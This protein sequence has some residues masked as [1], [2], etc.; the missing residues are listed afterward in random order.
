MEALVGEIAIETRVGAVTVSTAVLLVI[1]PDVAV[2]FEL[3]VLRLVATP[4]AL[5]EATELLLEF[6]VTEL[7]RSAVL[8]SV[9]VPVAVNGCVRPLAMEGLAGVTA[10]ETKVAAVTVSCAVPDLLVLGSVAVMVIG[11]PAA[12][13]VATP[14]FRPTVAV[15]VSDEVQFTDA[16]RFWVLL[17][18]YIPVAVNACVRPLA[19]EGLAGVTAME[20]KA[21]AVT[22]SCAVPDLLVLGSVAVMV[23][24]PPAA[25][26]VATPV[27]RPTVAVLVSDEV[28]F[29][30]A[31]RFWVL[32]SVYVP[33]AV[34]AWVKPLAIEGLAGV[35]A[36]ETKV[37]AVTVS[38]AVPDLL[39]LGSVAVMVIGPP[40]AAPV[41]TPVFR[42]TVAMLV[43][44]EVQFTDVVRFCVLLSV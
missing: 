9:Y 26:P 30:D 12:A 23:T 7:V 29:T 31:V 17:S 35:T 5:I 22:V 2:I 28:Q 11:P 3:P 13:P 25:A 27:F 37:A 16:V 19:M 20:T 8:L 15:L 32:L 40:A 42:P 39:V 33:V 44:D 4:P 6:Q 38:C 1:L 41:A 14:V 10:M 43:S 36:M 24:G 21:A 34:N 18:V